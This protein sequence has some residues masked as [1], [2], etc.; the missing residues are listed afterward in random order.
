MNFTKI[1]T[2]FHNFRF[3]NKLITRNYWFFKFNIIHTAKVS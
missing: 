1:A 2:N 3:H